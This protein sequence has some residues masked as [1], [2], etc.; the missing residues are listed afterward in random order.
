MTEQLNPTEAP[1]V[2][3]NQNVSVPVDGNDNGVGGDV[4]PGVDNGVDSAA[5]DDTNSVDN[6]GGSVVPSDFVD[7]TRDGSEPTSAMSSKEDFF[8]NLVE[9]SSFVVRLYVDKHDAG[10]KP[11][12]AEG[13]VVEGRLVNMWTREE[14]LPDQVE[15]V[16]GIEE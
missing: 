4:T 12:F 14:I 10:L 2:D 6:S 15:G 11:R 3:N 5:V 9:G 16:S 13:K 8:A 1:N 7:G